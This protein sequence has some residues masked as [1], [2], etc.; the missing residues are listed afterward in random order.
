MNLEE[1]VILIGMKWAIAIMGLGLTGIWLMA[2]KNFRNSAYR[3]IFMLKALVGLFWA[4]YYFQS[5]IGGIVTAHQIW[6]RAGILI[7]LSAS[8]AIGIAFLKERDQ[9]E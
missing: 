1:N 8:I 2:F 4:F 9:S 3:C 5:L 7:T 6:V